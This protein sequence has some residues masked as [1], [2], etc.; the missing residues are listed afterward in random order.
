MTKNNVIFS[1]IVNFI[2]QIHGFFPWL[3]VLDVSGAEKWLCS[4]VMADMVF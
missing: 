1:S 2:D 4:E 3:V